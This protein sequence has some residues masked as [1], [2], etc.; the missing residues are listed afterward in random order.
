MKNSN[1]TIE[2]RTHD[3]PACTAVPE[4]TA[5]PH[6]T[7]ASS[8]ELNNAW[9]YVFTIP[10]F[11]AVVLLNTKT[12]LGEAGISDIKAE[13]TCILVPF[14][15]IWIETILGEYNKVSYVL[16]VLTGL[17]LLQ[18]FKRNT[19]VLIDMWYLKSWASCHWSQA[20]SSMHP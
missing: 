8:T 14:M 9:S 11:P 13:S 18:V 7:S 6:A 1:D 19:C 17:P 4:P 10:C 12:S 15:A 5:P 2:N 3:L 16:V 20:P